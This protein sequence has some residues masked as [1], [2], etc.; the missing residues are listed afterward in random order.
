MESSSHRS[1]AERQKQLELRKQIKVLQARLTD[2]PDDDPRLQ[3]PKRRK[4]EATLLAPATPS[5]RKKR[6]IE[7]AVSQGRKPHAVGSSMSERPR[8]HDSARS[9]GKPASIPH[10]AKPA[11]SSVLG[12][13]ATLR[14]G[15]TFRS[16][17][18]LTLRSSDIAEKPKPKIPEPCAQSRALQERVV[19]AS[20]ASTSLASTPQRDENLAVVEE[21]QMGPADHKPPPDDPLFECLEP[22]SGIH[23]LSRSL[24]HED[25]Q[26]YLRGR[27]YLSPSRLYSCIQLLPNKSGYD[28]PVEG[29]WVTIAVVAERGVIKH[30]RA[31]VDITPG[32]DGRASD[33]ETG[34]SKS[35]YK[36]GARNKPDKNGPKGQTKPHCR[37]YVSMKLV[38]FGA[39]SRSSASAGKSTIRGDAFLTLLLFESDGFDKVTGEDGSVKKL[40]QGGSKGAFEAM[41]KLKEGDVVALL[42]PKV[43]KP[44][45]RNDK[46]PHPVD[47]ILAVTPES[48]TSMAIIGRARDLGM[49]KV[50]KKDG[51]PCGSWTD[52]R[53]S[54][55]CEWHLTN[56]V[57]RRRAGRAEFS[58]GT[59]GMTTTSARKRKPEYDPSRHWGLQP[60]PVAS[61]SVY[62]VS[63]HVVGGTAGNMFT[64]EKLG[65][66]AQEKAKRRL[67]QD[68]DK[69]L[70]TLL[71]RD[72]E[73]M[74]AVTKAREVAAKMLEASESV[75]EK[76][77]GKRASKGKGKAMEREDEDEDEEPVPASVPAK[78][79]YSASII[80]HLGFDPAAKTG[81][82]RAEDLA[83]Q[84]K[85][86][87]LAAVQGSRRVINLAR[88]PGPK[89][90]SGVSVPAFMIQEGSGVDTEEQDSDLD[91]V[92][93]EDEMVDLDE[94]SDA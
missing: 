80:K 39:R 7:Q 15:P 62:I 6:R 10:H 42:N 92:S 45:Q 59:S 69:E 83:I 29:D 1:Q 74:R 55:V 64:A 72:K 3:S 81:R 18:T 90:R 32:D 36:S 68:A 35:G 4:P 85:L 38:D 54:D 5:P 50:T 23:L 70:K 30:T 24:P 60:E 53:V 75:K 2:I 48:A 71:D 34:A 77:K 11:P 94:S 21:L 41:S 43:L 56:A 51:K 25:L 91:V 17:P 58:A 44:L 89:I 49:C 86:E 9:V 76:G 14:A 66:E 79:A 26:E 47:N 78:P 20:V 65:R 37:K 93:R 13:L 84:K 73:G 22:N 19:E 87:A 61:S 31:P 33:D 28:V 16:E 40:Y 52:K 57:Q 67:G 46:T 63:G 8:A 12:K 82:K 88:R 27:Y